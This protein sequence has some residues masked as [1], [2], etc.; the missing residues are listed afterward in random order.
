[1]H[2]KTPYTNLALSLLCSPLQLFNFSRAGCSMK[3]SRSYGFLA[4]LY[5]AQ[6]KNLPCPRISPWAAC[7]FYFLSRCYAAFGV[8]AFPFSCTHISSPPSCSRLTQCLCF[9]CQFIFLV[10]QKHCS[11]PWSECWMRNTQFVTVYANGKN[12]K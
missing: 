10:E 5:I 9:V 6:E 2:V 3:F 7:P 4:C 12:P 1:M 11:S 8:V